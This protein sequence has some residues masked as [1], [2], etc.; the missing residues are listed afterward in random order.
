M[1]VKANKGFT[2]IELL[3]VIA[4]IGLLSTVVMTSL[5]SARKKGRDTRRVEDINQLKTAL[6][7]YYDQN[8]KYPQALSDLVTAK[9]MSQIPKDP[10]GTAYDYGVNDTTTATDYA[11]R[12]ELETQHKGLNSDYDTADASANTS[13][14]YG[15]TC[16]GDD[17]AADGPY[18][19]CVKP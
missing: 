1:N 2:L 15:L 7:L 11:L 4:I 8:G 9:F 12:A 6:E 5:N 16:N 19:Y 14:T 17:T 10:D 3:V 18:D 13:E